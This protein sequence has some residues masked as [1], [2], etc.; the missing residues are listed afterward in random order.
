MF[1]WNV[2]KSYEC[3]LSS[4]QRIRPLF[5]DSAAWSEIVAL[6]RRRDAQGMWAL[7]LSI[8]IKKNI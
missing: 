7:N 3:F 2:T 6:S 8:P 5:G 1:V 4:A